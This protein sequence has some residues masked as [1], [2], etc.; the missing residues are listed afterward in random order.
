MVALS[1]QRRKQMQEGSGKGR[2]GSHSQL[3]VFRLLNCELFRCLHLGSIEGF[4]VVAVLLEFTYP[5]V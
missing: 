1:F 5:L 4:V 3:S 2:K